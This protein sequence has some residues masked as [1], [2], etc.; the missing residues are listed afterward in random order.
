M[1]QPIFGRAHWSAYDGSSG[2]PSATRSRSRLTLV[3]D[4]SARSESATDD[5][6][7]PGKDTA[8]I[9]SCGMASTSTA[10]ASARTA[11]WSAADVPAAK[12]T[13][14][15]TDAT[16]GG[17]VSSAEACS[18]GVVRPATTTAKTVTAARSGADPRIRSLNTSCRRC[19][20]PGVPKML[21][22]ADSAMLCPAP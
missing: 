10:P 11:A 17:V 13:R 19:R 16:A 20:P 3:T 9:R 4:G 12:V 2:V 5:A 14:Y 18:I 1:S 8:C 15:E 21:L 6:V 7:S 22:R